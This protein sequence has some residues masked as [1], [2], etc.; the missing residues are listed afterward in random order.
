MGDAR[1]TSMT[2]SRRLL[3]K[4]AQSLTATQI[5]E[6]IDEMLDASGMDADERVEFLGGLFVTEAV[7]PFTRPGVS[8]IAA[9]ERMRHFDP[10]LADAVESISPMLLGRATARHDAAA[11]ARA[12]SRSSPISA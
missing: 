4:A 9:H 8:A 2:Q 1:M 5:A 11:A 7:R 12:W 10:E 6:I 3:A